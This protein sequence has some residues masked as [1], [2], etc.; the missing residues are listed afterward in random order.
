[1]VGM[2]Q[3]D[4]V[5]WHTRKFEDSPA[6]LLALDRLCEAGDG[7]EFENPKFEQ[8][9]RRQ[10]CANHVVQSGLVGL[11]EHDVNLVHVFFF[12]G[13]LLKKYSAHADVSEQVCVQFFVARFDCLQS[14]HHRSECDCGG[15]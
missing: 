9:V 13:V 1:M 14:E 4:D 11:T 5:R 6:H 3:V 7:R 12:G 8:S 15:F 10:S 2:L